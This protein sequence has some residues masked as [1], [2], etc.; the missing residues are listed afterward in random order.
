MYLPFLQ[1]D[2]AEHNHIHGDVKRAVSNAG[3]PSSLKSLA[4]Q[5][6]IPELLG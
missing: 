1:V 3:T 2:E 4:E 5:C 6:Q